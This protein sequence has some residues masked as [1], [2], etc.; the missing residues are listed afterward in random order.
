VEGK[1]RRQAENIAGDK[2]GDE[3]TAPAAEP[4]RA[5]VTQ[6]T[7]DG[8]PDEYS[9]R[10]QHV[11]LRIA[12]PANQAA[13]QIMAEAK[14][15]SAERSVKLMSMYVENEVNPPRNPVDHHAGEGL[16]PMRRHPT[17]LI[18]TRVSAS[19]AGSAVSA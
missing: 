9:E 3:H 18:A 16:A 14:R 15:Y 6:E 1:E 8:S 2:V 10:G 12:S 7:T 19:P 5:T 13:T 17:A 4:P 11:R